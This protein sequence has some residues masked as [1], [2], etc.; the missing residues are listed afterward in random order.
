MLL[1]TYTG[2]RLKIC[3]VIS[4]EVKYK[5]RKA[6][7]DLLVVAGDGPSLMGRDWLGELTLKLRRATLVAKTK[8]LRSAEGDFSRRAGQ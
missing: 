4:L 7:L 2:E 1:R 8:R 5:D 6:R 3:G